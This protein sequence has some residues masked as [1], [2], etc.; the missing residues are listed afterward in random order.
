MVF[1]RNIA[2]LCVTLYLTPLTG[3]M[4]SE[5]ECDTTVNGVVKTAYV[6]QDLDIN[7]SDDNPVLQTAVALTCGAWTFDFWNSVQ[8][9][10]GGSYGTRGGDEIDWTVT[11]APSLG[12]GF[13]SNFSVAWFMIPG[14]NGIGPWEDDII[15]LHAEVGY[16]FAIGDTGA[17]LTPFVREIGLLGTE[18]ARNYHITRLG[19]RLT[20]PITDTFSFNGDVANAFNHTDHEAAFRYSAQFNAEMLDGTWYTGVE[21]TDH[22]T[23]LMIGSSYTF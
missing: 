1:L 11:Y 3:A 7:A 21:G 10:G 14:P 16:P 18:S 5:R 22:F 20:V 23:A 19:V 6:L 17:T 8:V 9:A 2:L 4:A 15:S 13:T 12:G